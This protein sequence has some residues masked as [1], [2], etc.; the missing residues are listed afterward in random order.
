MFVYS[1]NIVGVKQVKQ[2]KDKKRIYLRW[3]RRKRKKRKYTFSGI[4]FPVEGR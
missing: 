3:K 2:N 4:Q 1:F